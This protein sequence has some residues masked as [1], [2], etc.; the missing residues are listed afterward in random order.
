LI[1]VLTGAE[2]FLFGAQN[3]L[4]GTDVWAGDREGGGRGKKELIA[5]APASSQLQVR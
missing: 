4:E 1:P 2:V 3:L 5:M